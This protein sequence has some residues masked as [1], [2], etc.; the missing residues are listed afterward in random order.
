MTQGLLLDG[1]GKG[2]TFDILEGHDYAFYT[3]YDEEAFR[4]RP[5]YYTPTGEIIDDSFGETFS[6][7]K[8]NSTG[9]WKPLPPRSL[10]D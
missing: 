7:F 10:K 1:V 9:A 3:E 4:A 2:E 5:H 8:L 6:T